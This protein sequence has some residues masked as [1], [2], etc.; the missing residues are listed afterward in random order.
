MS[1]IIILAEIGGTGEA[2]K[3][4]DK[5]IKV[6]FHYQNQVIERTIFSS[7]TPIIDY[8]QIRIDIEFLLRNNFGLLRKDFPVSLPVTIEMPNNTEQVTLKIEYH[9]NCNHL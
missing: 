7:L 6:K 2:K 4:M 8:K 3:F 5:E 9:E 1:H